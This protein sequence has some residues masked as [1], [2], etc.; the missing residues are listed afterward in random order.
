MMTLDDSKII[1]LYFERNEC[2]IHETDI[3]YGRLLRHI[4]YSILR[5]SDDSEE[6]VDDTYMK[7][8]QSVP[9]ERPGYFKAFL[10][11]I[12]RN[13]SINRYNSNKRGLALTTDTALEELEECIPATDGEIADDIELCDALNS[14]LSSLGKT[15]RQVFVKRYFYMMSVREIS[16]DLSLTSSNVKVILMRTR[17]RLREH[18]EKAGITV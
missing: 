16:K 12:T 10:A 13:I 3:K 15:H 5:S 17:E 6:C 1:D 18:L 2:A 11:R 14:F 4:S 8:W 9:P 7:T